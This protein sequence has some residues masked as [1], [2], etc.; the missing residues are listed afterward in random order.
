MNRKKKNISKS[1]FDNPDDEKVEETWIAS[2]KGKVNEEIKILRDKHLSIAEKKKKGWE[3][4]MQEMKMW[5]QRNTFRKKRKKI[6]SPQGGK[7]SK[8]QVMD[9]IKHSTHAS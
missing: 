9:G 3:V 6:E 4:C 2:N 5:K 7:D 8:I 1:K